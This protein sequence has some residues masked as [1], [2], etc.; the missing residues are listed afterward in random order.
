MRKLAQNNKFTL[1]FL[2]VSFI[3]LRHNL[4][5]TIIITYFAYSSPCLLCL[6]E[7]SAENKTK[8]LLIGL[9]SIKSSVAAAT[10][11]EAS[12][13]KPC[14]VIGQLKDYLTHETSGCINHKRD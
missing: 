2:C 7:A 12:G 3:F 5:M 14:L 11:E 8:Y 9:V 6:S 13:D 10:A 1:S 4:G